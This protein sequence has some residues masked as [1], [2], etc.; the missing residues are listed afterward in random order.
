MDLPNELITLIFNKLGV[1]DSLFLM[2]TCKKL[3]KFEGLEDKIKTCSYMNDIYKENDFS[4]EKI[5]V[6]MMYVSGKGYLDIAKKL[7][8]RSIEN[9]H[10][11]M[12]AAFGNNHRDIGLYLFKHIRHRET[13]DGEDEGVIKNM[14]RYSLINN[15]NYLVKKL[16]K[17]DVALLRNFVET[18]C[19]IG[20]YDMFIKYH[21]LCSQICSCGFCL[22]K[23]GYY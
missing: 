17:Y 21:N 3:C 19:L 10:E 1:I 4:T 12:E 6:A 15:D 14:V 11:C 8:H 5:E 9:L 2:N 20:N 16:I 23:N 7:I 13:Y 22:N 18:A